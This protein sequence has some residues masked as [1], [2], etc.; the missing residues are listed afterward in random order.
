MEVAMMERQR[1]EAHAVQCRRN[2]AAAKTAKSIASNSKVNALHH[3]CT[4]HAISAVAW[5]Q[6]QY[7]SLSA[8][9]LLS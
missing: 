2:T 4:D 5:H 9:N 1:A 8:S 3:P 6:R 7:V